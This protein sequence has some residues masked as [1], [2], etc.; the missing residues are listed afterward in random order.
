[1]PKISKVL[2]VK[3]VKALNG[4]GLYSLGGAN[5]LYLQIVKDRRYFVFRYS[6]ENKRKK[7]FIGNYHSLSLSDARTKANEFN[8][9]LDSGHD[10]AE[11]ANSNSAASKRLNVSNFE[12]LALK[13]AREREING[14]WKN[15]VRGHRD[16]VNRLKRYAFPLLSKKSV[17]DIEA[18]DILEVVRPIYYHQNSLCKKL[19]GSLRAIF[20][21]SIAFGYRKKT[22]NPA[23]LEEALGIL[24]ESLGKPSESQNFAGLNFKEI[25]QFIADISR[26]K[27]RSSQMLIFSIL[28]ASRSQA[29]RFARWSDIDLEKGIWEIPLQY[30]KSKTPHANRTI[31]LSQ[32]ALTLLTQVFRFPETDFVFSNS[33]GNAYSDAAMTQVIRKAHARKKAA[34]NIGWI[35]FEKSKLNGKDCIITQ[36]ATARRTFKTWAKDDVLGNNRKFDQEA[37]ELCLLH[38]RQDPYKGAYDRSKMEIERRK[39]MEEW[40]EFCM[41]KTSFE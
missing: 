21:W 14:Y 20:R 24:L 10:P 26:L 39:I 19:L 37:V 3:E 8:S 17:E 25:P 41:S 7:I 16:T 12:Q 29:V 15:N 4:D 38:S 9:M 33:E 40:G 5:R 11:A 30:D 13:W 2:S 22:N 18:A 31:Y 28:T 36:H 6:F 34:D 32:A 1:M 35:D 23:S 27:S